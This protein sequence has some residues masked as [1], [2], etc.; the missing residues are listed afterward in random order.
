[1][2]ANHHLRRAIRT[3]T[4]VAVLLT[5]SLTPASGTDDKAYE[6]DRRRTTI[7][8]HAAW[9]QAFT[10]VCRDQAPQISAHLVQAFDD[11]WEENTL[12]REIL[13]GS[14]FG[15]IPGEATEIRKLHES[16]KSKAAVAFDEKR[17]TDPDG[18]AQE[19]NAFT[20][21]L[22]AGELDYRKGEASPN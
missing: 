4:M 16:L 18:F 3:M 19:C 12:I 22:A 21:E 5:S 8:A 11:W 10:T 1:M 17:K 14:E 15:L 13:S 7:L 20:R 6:I 2:S 9:V